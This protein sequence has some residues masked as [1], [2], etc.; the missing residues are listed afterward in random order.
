MWQKRKEGKSWGTGFL[1]SLPPL[2]SLAGACSPAVC[3]HRSNNN[4]T[5]GEHSGNTDFHWLSV[6]T[7]V[8]VCRRLSVMA[9]PV[10]PC[11][12]YGTPYCSPDPS[13]SGFWFFQR[14]E[15]LVLVCICGTPD[16]LT[17]PSLGVHLLCKSMR[18]V[19]VCHLYVH[20]PLSGVLSF[21]FPADGRWRAPQGGREGCWL[22]PC[23]WPFAA[24]FS[25]HV[26]SVFA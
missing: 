23:H 3:G 19:G 24:C 18:T 8:C 11:S 1:P 25:R 2:L 20:W 5:L 22:F 26:W 6:S 7:R 12:R 15:L 9:L 17:L 13:G 16:P 4:V 10:M 21:F 14:A